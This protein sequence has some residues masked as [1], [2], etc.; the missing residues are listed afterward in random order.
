TPLFF[1]ANRQIVGIFAVADVLKPTSKA[2][3]EALHSMHIDVTLLTGD[4]QKTAQSIASEL[5]VTDVIAEVLPQDK[6]RIVREKQGKNRKVAMIGDGI[7]DAPAL[8]RADVGIAIGAGTDV[9]ISSADVVLM[10]SDLMDA[11]DAIR[12][13]RRTMRNIRQNL[14]WAFF[15]NCI[16]I[17]IAAGLLWVPFGIKLSPMIGAAA[18]SL[19]SVCVVSNALRLRFFSATQ[20]KT[21]GTPA[22]LPVSGEK[23][24]TA[25][26]KEENVMEKTI[27][28]E[29]MMCQHCVA[30]VK[31]ALEGAAAG[32]NVAVDLD[33]GKAVVSGK[34]LPEDAVLTAAVTEAGYEVV[35]I[36]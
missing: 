3:V 23:P 5:G 24:L 11:V 17:P 27:K 16:G 10:K 25:H 9:A 32:C 22:V 21:A 31:K 7:N 14:F 2:A 20:R 34:T 33:A 4:N 36:K 1:A 29:G 26:K 15:Y 6:E 30:H 19:S 13:S 8:A 18:M 35:D 12:L 28:V